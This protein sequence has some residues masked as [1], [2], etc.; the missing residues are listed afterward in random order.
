[1]GIFEPITC[2][3]LAGVLPGLS[4]VEI[5]VP[6]DEEP[7]KVKKKAGKGGRQSLPGGHEARLTS[8]V[9]L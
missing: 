2:K 8:R 5:T 6:P 4:Q 9:R 7:P 3:S 1:M